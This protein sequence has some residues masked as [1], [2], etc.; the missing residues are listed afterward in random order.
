MTGEWKNTETS[1]LVKPSTTLIMYIGI[2]ILSQYEEI[3]DDTISF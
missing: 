1:P 3:C 2:G